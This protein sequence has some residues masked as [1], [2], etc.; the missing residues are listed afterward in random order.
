MF[1]SIFGE[2]SD[3]YN[4]L[5]Q[6][7]RNLNYILVQNKELNDLNKYFNRFQDFL[8]LLSK[9]YHKIIYKT[10]NILIPYLNESIN[11]N[12]YLFLPFSIINYLLY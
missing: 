1:S 10:I 4:Q 11:N 6:Y 12:F 3:I 9:D 8:L 7:E 2:E 5:R